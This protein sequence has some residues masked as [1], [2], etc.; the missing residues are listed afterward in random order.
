MREESASSS[1]MSTPAQKPR[2]SA[3]RTTARTS[4][5]RPSA[6]RRS[7][8][9]AHSWLASAFT[10]GLFSTT[11]ATP[12]PSFTSKAIASTSAAERRERT[13][14]L[15][16]DA[17]D[18]LRAAR[19]V[20][21]Q[22]GHRPAREVAAHRVAVAH[23]ALREH[24]R[25]RGHQHLRACEPLALA[26][27]EG[28]AQELRDARARDLAVRERAPER[29]EQEQRAAAPLEPVHELVAYHALREAV[30][31]IRDEDVVDARLEVALRGGVRDG[32]LAREQE[33]R[34]HRDPGGAP[35]ERRDEAAAVAE[36]AGGDHRHVHRVDA[37]GDE[38]RGRE[39]AR[40]P[41]SLAALDDDRVGAELL[42]LHRVPRRAAGRDAG[43]AR[44]LEARDDL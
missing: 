8:R 14:R 5:S 10:C 37:G 20:V 42:R 34:A 15:L 24:R 2:P 41:S 22:P 40:V 7:A 17:P 3:A 30:D 33:A 38:Q 25:V 19:A 26:Q 23:A 18:E 36:A 27:G 29:A 28:R 21:D 31:A 1:L 35:G 12:S 4:G 39:G 6:A 44:L 11:S 16:H 32:A 43:D 13:L 9:A